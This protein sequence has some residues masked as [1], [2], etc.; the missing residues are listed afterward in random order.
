MPSRS[1]RLYWK[2]SVSRLDAMTRHSWNTW[3]PPL[4]WFRRPTRSARRRLNP[5]RPKGVRGIKQAQSFLRLL[6]DA[7][8]TNRPERGN[9]SLYVSSIWCGYHFIDHPTRWHRIIPRLV[10]MEDPFDRTRMSLEVHSILRS[11]LEISRQLASEFPAHLTYRQA[12][13]NLCM[14]YSISEPPSPY[15]PSPVRKLATP[16]QATFGLTAAWSPSSETQSIR[17][18]SRGPERRLCRSV[19][20]SNRALARG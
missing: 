3:R 13:R 17:K 16:T 10:R 4:A 5:M 6:K 15:G 19:L 7:K 8:R 2:L 9:D 20:Y 1:C 14:A 18:V 11:V 12:V